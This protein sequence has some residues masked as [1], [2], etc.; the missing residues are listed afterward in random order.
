MSSGTWTLQN[1][2]DTDWN[3]GGQ[4]KSAGVS[5]AWFIHLPEQLATYIN[6]LNVATF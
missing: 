1:M 4:L 6:I 2:K 3:K 5:T